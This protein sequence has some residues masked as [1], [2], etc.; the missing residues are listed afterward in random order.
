VIKSH[1]QVDGQAKYVIE[2]EVG[3]YLVLPADSHIAA[4]AFYV[5]NEVTVRQGHCL[6]ILLAATGKKHC[7]CI[8][9]AAPADCIQQHSQRQLRLQCSLELVAGGD[10]CHQILYHDHTLH[11][12]AVDLL[13]QGTRGDNGGKPTLLPGIPDVSLRSG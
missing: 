11:Q 3:K 10:A 13:K 9:L 1:P 4:E 7:S 2:Y 8:I 12:R 5:G 6:R